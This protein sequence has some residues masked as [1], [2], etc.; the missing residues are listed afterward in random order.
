MD[1]ISLTL[2]E[3][4][5]VVGQSSTAINRAVDR[6]IIK[7]TFE[8]RGKSRLRKIGSPELRFLAIAGEVEK[9][10]TPAARRKVYE[11]MRR[12]PPDADLLSVGIMEFR[13]GDVDRR[14]AGRLRQLQAVKKIIEE[15]S[16]ADP[17]IS[18]TEVSAYVVA[19]LAHGETIAEII[20]DYPGL[21]PEQIEAAVEYA[22]VYPRPGRPLP[23]RSFKKALA[24][25]AEAGVWDV[26]SD[27]AAAGRSPRP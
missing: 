14:I 3:A 7:A 25:M 5:Y 10:L 20:G 19:A 16:G 4:G 27:D 2:N 21:K 26:G 15:R 24:D 18:G 1:A 9:D 11:A 17:V 22:K 8:R 23:G 13:L 6:G 12:L